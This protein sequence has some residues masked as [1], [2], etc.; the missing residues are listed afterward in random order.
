MKE[1]YDV[2]IIGGGLVGS[3]TAYFL[4]RNP[5]FRGRILVLERD[6][7][8]RKSASA[9]S[10]SGFRQ[11]FSTGVNI[12]LSRFS[13]DF[14]RKADRWLGLDGASPGIRLNEAGYLYLGGPESVPA[15]T[16]NHRLQR[17]FGVDVALLEPAEIKQRFPWLN[18]EDVAI[19]SLG[20]SGEGWM[21]AYLLLTAFG[22]KARSF[23]VEYRFQ[24]V[25]GLG[26]EQDERF[27]I[28]LAG[29]GQIHADHVV[30]AAGTRAPGIAK[31][32][33]IDVPVAPVKQ[34][35]YMFESPFDCVNAP[36]V[37]TPD[38]V[39][40]RREG[41][42][43]LCG[44]GI[45]SNPAVVDLDDFE[46]DY[47]RFEEVLWPRLAYRV[48]GFEALRLKRS[49]AGHYDMSLFDHNPFIGRVAGY[50]RFYLATGFSGH[51]MMQSPGVGC[52]L[53]EMIIYGENRSLDLSDLSFNRLQQQ[54]AAIELIQY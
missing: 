36:F 2:A 53:S 23:G 33:G 1:H 8:Y 12:A 21:D 38:G 46:V 40:F 39:F 4:A 51:G 54:P 7:T 14:I 37:F 5:D 25:V 47:A 24:E 10:T 49:W 27:S 44:L 9:L 48:A 29:G 28:R 43:Y 6:R 13:I 11:Q 16:A 32:L 15:F 19:G 31:M 17:S 52:A 26:I 34:A 42:E 50:L 3:A 41:N 18:L 20:L 35:V 45:G 30:N 22:T